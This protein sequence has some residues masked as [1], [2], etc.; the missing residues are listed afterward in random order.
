MD[1]ATIV[2]LIVSGLA[3]GAVYSLV[4]EGFYIAFRITTTLNFGQGDFLMLGCFI[5]LL[6]IHMGL[7]F[8]VILVLLVCVMA[9]LGIILERIAIRPV[10]RAGL[11]F[12]LT[13]MGFAMI[14][15]NSVTAL[16][17]NTAK[18]FPSFFGGGRE[19][20][21]RIW[22]IGFFPEELFIILVSLLVMILF[23]ILLHR[24][25][26]GKAFSAVSFNPDTA[27]IL[28][29]NVKRMKVLAYVIASVLA[30]LSGFLIGP[31]TTVEPF[32]GFK[33][34]LKGF[35]AA[36]LG[37][38]LNPVGILVGGLMLGLIEN[39]ASLFT[40]QYRDMISFLVIIVVLIFR[41][42]GLFREQEVRPG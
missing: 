17:G 5:S 6:F 36:I 30:G 26:I 4:A 27:S 16:W 25:L 7:P 22:G 20:A 9:I 3:V 29:I 39:F 2:Q 23:L 31:I 13:T 38:F 18:P 15:Q 42:S 24:T 37:G 12:I 33:W 41:P 32:M 34:T 35:V 1:T 14:M 40:S 28:G 19:K 21:I 8:Y 10:A 11:S